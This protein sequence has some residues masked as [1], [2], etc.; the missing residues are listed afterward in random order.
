M[1]T[2][3]GFIGV[4]PGGESP[5]VIGRCAVIRLRYLSLSAESCTA[6]TI[7]TCDLVAIAAVGW[8]VGLALEATKVGRVGLFIVGPCCSTRTY[9][10]PISNQSP[11]SGAQ[12]RRLRL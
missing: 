6:L 7:W 10:E 5:I 11:I 12:F 3:A 1:G 2:N 4:D 8:A 9:R